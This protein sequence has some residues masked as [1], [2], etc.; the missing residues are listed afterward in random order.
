MRVLMLLSNT[1]GKG[2]YWRA[3]HLARHLSFRGHELTVVATPSKRRLRFCTHL[4]TQSNVT[5]VEAPDIIG[6]PVRYGWD[7]WS[8]AA[9]TVWAH[10]QRFDL[11][12]GF[13]SRPT[14]ILPAL[15]LQRFRGT[16]LVLDWCDWFG[17]GGSVEERPSWLIRVLLGRIETFFEEN[18][19]VW[20]DGTSV[21]NQFLYLRATEL[22][23][24]S[25]TIVHLPNGSDISGL[26]PIP[27]TEARTAV[28]LPLDVPI[29]GYIGAIFHRDAQLMSQA[30]DKILLSE[31]KARLLL[32][33]YCNANVEEMVS[34]PAAV[35]RTGRLSYEQINNYLAA[36]DIFW[37]PL[38][39]SGA[40]RG[41]FPLKIN[42]YMAVGRP[43]VATSVGEVADLIRQG[44]FGSV[45]ADQP[46]EIAVAVVSLLHNP[47][48]G[49]RMG[50]R[51]REI[52]ETELS[53]ERMSLKLEGFY[54]KVLRGDWK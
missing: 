46:D 17:R 11:V 52:A 41:R 37:L 15:Y 26:R 35:W 44:G 38:R 31:P 36:C 51:A 19:R 32:A 40:N 10:K 42:D 8:L 25:E 4:D 45:T 3:L 6:G 16:P 54:H 20:A 18:F 39:D 33:G 50:S 2:T 47:A 21:I 53:W 5:L 27:K 34:Q 1:A 14:T 22:G 13:E 49:E 9:R 24:P 7:P 29:I 28:G 30:F 23:V 12:H 48:E 43:V